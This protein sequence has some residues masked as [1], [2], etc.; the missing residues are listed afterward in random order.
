M[1]NP[2]VTIGDTVNTPFKPTVKRKTFARV[3]YDSQDF[4]TYDAT[5]YPA[6]NPTGK[7]DVFFAFVPFLPSNGPSAP[8]FT[9]SDLWDSLQKAPSGFVT[10][11]NS[12]MPKIVVPSKLIVDNGFKSFNTKFLGLWQDGS[13]FYDNFSWELI[14]FN[15][16]SI[17]LAD[18]TKYAQTGPN[19]G[20]QYVSIKAKSDNSVTGDVLIMKLEEPTG[21]PYPL[22]PHADYTGKLVMN[23]AFILMLNIVP[24]RNT[25][26]DP[27]YGA[28]NAWNMTLEFGEVKM[29]ISDNGSTQVELGQ[30]GSG[31]TNRTTI[32]L[33]VGKTADGPRQQQHITEKDPYIIL[34]YPVWNGLVIA[35]GVQDARATVFSSSYYVPKLKSAGILNSTYSDAFDPQNPPITGDIEVKAPATVM[36]DMGS[37]LTLT[38]KNCRF[39]VAYEPCYFAKKCWFDEWRIYPED[40]P[41]TE[42]YTYDIY[43]IWTKNNTASVLQPS[44]PTVYNSGYSSELE[45]TYY[46]VIAWGLNSDITTPLYNRMGA[47]IFGSILQ[48][49]EELDFPI[50]NG[51]GHFSLNFTG[52]TS[53][54]PSV[55]SNWQDYVQSITVTTN[56]DGSSGSVVVD[57]Y[58]FAGQDAEIV[59]S[60]GAITIDA[61][62]G[63]GTVGGNLFQGL[64]MGASDNRSS[65]GATCSIPLVGLE[66]KLDDIMLI[67][68]PFFDGDTFS[69]TTNFLT[70][71]AGISSDLTHADPTVRLG[72]TD[73]INAV[74]FDWKSGTTVRSALDDVMADTLHKYVVVDGSIKFYQINPSSGLPYALGRDWKGDYPDTKVVMYDASPDFEDLR[75]TIIVLGLEQVADG[76]G[77]KLEDLPAFPRMVAIKNDTTPDVPWARV[78]VS[79]KPG[80]LNVSKITQMAQNLAIAS[81]VYELMG[82]TTIAG[83][84]LIRPYDQWGDLVIV[85]VTQNIDLK[86]KTWTTDLEFMRNTLNFTTKSSI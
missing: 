45:G 38:A 83:N 59:Q 9:A 36:V 29:I 30:T 81:S 12:I 40:V 72:V 14:S 16:G 84:A 1:S 24:T 47:E 19:N 85:G 61:T 53:G 79:P 64:A 49:N 69:N 26:V 48:T 5:E 7:G 3:V 66:K 54:D 57:K 11:V 35:S 74:R 43:P 17:A 73:D 21:S 39:E 6:F 75:N 25:S 62:G 80:M 32:N 33:A 52:G 27:K 4:F 46:G 2:V 86:S 31:E 28:D 70:T 67:N 41:A 13:T 50:K 37:D 51:N 10:A 55:T 78:I 8:S 65:D 68:A 44:P 15:G 56:H 22:P 42:T 76:Q 82:R 58:G 60:I 23:G 63:N 18:A 71:Y 77:S 20:S 34:V